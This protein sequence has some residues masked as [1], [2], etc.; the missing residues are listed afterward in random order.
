MFHLRYIGSTDRIRTC[1]ILVLSE[2]PPSNW[3]T[4]PLN[5]F[6]GPG[7]NRT[8]NRLLAKQSRLPLEHAS[9]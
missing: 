2:T 9:P 6:G 4:V 8:H 7:E 5:K 3:A 1:T